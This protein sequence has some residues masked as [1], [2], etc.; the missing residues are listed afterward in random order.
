MSMERLA[1]L[2]NVGI[3]PELS[4]P[5]AKRVRVTNILAIAFA[6]ISLI[7]SGIFIATNATWT[8]ILTIPVAASFGCAVLLNRMRF[9]TASRFWVC[10]TLNLVIYIYSLSFGRVSGIHFWF[11]PAIQIPFLFFDLRERHHL[12]ASTV[13]SLALFLSLWMNDF[14]SNLLPTVDVTPAALKVISGAMILI[15]FMVSLQIVRYIVGDYQNVS[16]LQANTAHLY[17]MNM[18][19]LNASSI[20][21]FTD[22]TGRIT[23]VND[24]FCKISGYERHE[25]IGKTHS[26]VNSGY[27]PKNFFKDMWATI[28]S[29][30]IWEGELCN[31]AKDG[32]FY[33]VHTT[34]VP[35]TDVNGRIEQYG[36][37]RHEITQRKTAEQASIQSA[38]LASLGEMSGS[39]AHEI[40][41]PVGII[42]G[43]ASQLLK[44]IHAGKFTSEKGIAQLEKV[45][46]EAERI[47]KIIHGLRTLSRNGDKDPFMSV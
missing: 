3:R 41:N 26:L 33:W 35:M 8:G 22:T 21:A 16:A 47:A 38:R 24:K 39:I 12:L 17:D 18:L 34:I 14:Q 19:V 45:V 44:L 46:S 28:S 9:Y 42:Q 32:T 13:L 2:A 5:L 15:S 36:A 30:R 29:N 1:S 27:H 40:N 10:L 7:Y 31:K 20:I 23:Y 11:F 4:Q 43:K 37:I 6:L 25:L